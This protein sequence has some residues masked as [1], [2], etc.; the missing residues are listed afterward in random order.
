[1]TLSS[2][3]QSSRVG[4]VMV[5]YRPS[6]SAYLCPRM[7]ARAAGAGARSIERLLHQIDQPLADDPGI[8]EGQLEPLSRALVVELGDQRLAHAVGPAPEEE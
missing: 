2:R 5:R 3:P 7:A 6:T 1:M 8:V 4:W